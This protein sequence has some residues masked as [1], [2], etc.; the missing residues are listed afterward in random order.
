VA[1]LLF[2]PDVANPTQSRYIY[3][4]ILTPGNISSPRET[5]V[6]SDHRP[7]M[8]EYLMGIAIAVRTRA[9]CL[10]SRIGAVVALNGR[11]VSTGYNGTPENM[12][13][14]LDGGCHRCANRDQYPS[15]SGYDL[16]I[17]VHAEQNAILSAARFGIAIEGSTV[18]TTMRPCFSCTKEMLQARVRAVYYLHDWSHPN[19][20]HKAE[21]ERLQA[22]FDGGIRRLDMPDPD[23]EWARR[24]RSVQTSESA[25]PI[26]TD[27]H[28]A[29]EV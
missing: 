15:G 12:P 1:T 5:F 29:Q 7:D 6:T 18:Y 3:S 22:R 26:S 10:G 20:A 27:Q 9:N 17:C 19:P 25:G 24:K 11:V 23:A 16:C 28:G 8:N 21:Y 4:F 2:A 14:C 13:N